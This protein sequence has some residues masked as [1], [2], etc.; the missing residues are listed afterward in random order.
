MPSAQRYCGRPIPG[1]SAA[2]PSPQVALRHALSAYNTGHFT[3]GFRNGYVDKY[4]PLV[5]TQ[6]NKAIYAAETRIPLG[7]L[8][9]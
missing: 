6:D 1:P 9:N 7:N 5:D 3:R 4:P 2:T 8:Y